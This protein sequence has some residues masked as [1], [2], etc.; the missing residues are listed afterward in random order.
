MK[1]NLISD[2]LK[3]T[4]YLNSKTMLILTKYQHMSYFS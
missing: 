4:N 3:S 1:I 2:Y